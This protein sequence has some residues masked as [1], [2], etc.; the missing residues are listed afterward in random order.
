[1]PRRPPSA[2]RT[3]REVRAARNKALLTG[4]LRCGRCGKGMFRG[5]NNCKP[6]YHCRSAHGFSGCGKLAVIAEPVEKI[7]VEAVLVALDTPALSAAV[8]NH[9][10]ERID[11]A[12]LEARLAEL[13]EM[14]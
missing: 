14:W 4:V 7:V 8:D 13:A 3:A 10:P 2:S 5:T 1:H 6:A 9:Q 11:T 12:A